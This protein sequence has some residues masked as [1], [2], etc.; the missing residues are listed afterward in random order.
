MSKEILE[1]VLK[2]AEETFKE[3]MTEYL[4]Q[5]KPNKIIYDTWFE[6]MQAL[7][8]IVNDL[9]T[10]D[11]LEKYYEFYEEKQK[12]LMRHLNS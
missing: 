6:V 5:E 4:L 9:C 2:I 10:L 12:R 8:S 1:S 3:A 11:E 7:E